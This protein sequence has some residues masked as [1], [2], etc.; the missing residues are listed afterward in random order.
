MP[1]DIHDDDF[2]LL[3]EANEE[4]NREKVYPSDQFQNEPE[5]ITEDRGM[6]IKHR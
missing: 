6:Q 5:E 3:A 4:A 2:K 1:P